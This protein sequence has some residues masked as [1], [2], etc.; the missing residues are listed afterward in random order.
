VTPSLILRDETIR[1]R[2]IERIKALKLDAPEPWAVYIAPHTQI[3]SLEANSFYWRQVGLV[4]AATGHGKEAL[5]EYFKRKAWGVVV[6]VVG[7][8]SIER[9]RSS[10]KASRGDF[11]ELVEVVNEFIAEHG[12]EESC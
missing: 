1:Q 12:I 6:D 2:A 11:S 3:R 8:Q 4:Q 10:A 7:G 9:S 5:H